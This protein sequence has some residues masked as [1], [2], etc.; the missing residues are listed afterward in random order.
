M[1]LFHTKSLVLGLFCLLHFGASTFAEKVLAT[2]KFDSDGIA[3]WQLTRDDRNR[4]PDFN[5]VTDPENPTAGVMEYTFQLDGGD[6]PIEGAREIKSSQFLQDIEVPVGVEIFLRVPMRCSKD[7]RQVRFAIVDST[8][9]SFLTEPQRVPVVGAEMLF[10]LNKFSSKWGGAGSE[11]IAWPVR[12]LTL[13]SVW[14]GG[15]APESPE[16][17][18]IEKIELVINE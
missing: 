7:G 5:F 17:L 8:G 13:Q 9:Q 2:A 6:K 4:D 14:W 18:W 10:S 11:N 1:L 16:S 12:S 3:A 15:P